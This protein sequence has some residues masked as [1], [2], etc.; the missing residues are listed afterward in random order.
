M[1]HSGAAAIETY[2][3]ELEMCRDFAQMARINCKFA[4]KEDATTDGDAA[5]RIVSS[6]AQAYDEIRGS[7]RK[8]LCV[9]FDWNYGNQSGQDWISYSLPNSSVTD[10]YVERHLGHLVIERIAQALYRGFHWEDEYVGD[11][12]V[13]D[14]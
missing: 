13:V 10:T 14:A 6:F 5:A 4:I 8:S 11:V 2:R 7:D 12:T 9:V 1:G 3:R